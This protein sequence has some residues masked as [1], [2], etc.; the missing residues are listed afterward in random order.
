MRHAHSGYKYST[1]MENT[2]NKS[3]IIIT[4]QLNRHKVTSQKALGNDL[5]LCYTPHTNRIM[6]HIPAIMSQ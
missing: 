4:I 1:K 5:P 6:W 2:E 3:I